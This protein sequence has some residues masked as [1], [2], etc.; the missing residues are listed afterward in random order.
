MHKHVGDMNNLNG[1][2]KKSIEWGKCGK[3]SP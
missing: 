3:N 1:F 2:G